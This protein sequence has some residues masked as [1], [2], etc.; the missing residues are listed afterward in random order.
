MA[1]SERVEACSRKREKGATVNSPG[2]MARQ[3]GGLGGLGQPREYNT[4]L[5][6]ISTDQMDDFH[7]VSDTRLMSTYVFTPIYGE[8]KLPIFTM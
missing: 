3:I 5:G 4:T 6:T 1:R 8:V 7:H 2:E